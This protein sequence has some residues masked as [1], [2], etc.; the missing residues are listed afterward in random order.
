MQ[1]ISLLIPEHEKPCPDPNSIGAPPHHRH[2]E[3][4][5]NNRRKKRRSKLNSKNQNQRQKNEQREM[6]NT[7]SEYVLK[8]GGE[9]GEAARGDSGFGES[10]KE[11]AD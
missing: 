1:H 10:E 7:E 6:K 2:A 3:L 5:N 4:E 11:R 8:S 9:A